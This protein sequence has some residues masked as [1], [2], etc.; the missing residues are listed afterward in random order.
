MKG[1]INIGNTCYLNAG[2]QMLIQ[3]VALCNLIKEYSNSSQILQVLDNFINDYYST[4]KNPIAPINIKK[5]IEQKQEIFTGAGQ[6]DSTEFIIYLLDIIDT[7]INRVS[8]NKI[9]EINSIFGIKFNVSIKCKI[10]ECLQISSH[11]EY[12]SILLLNINSECTSLDDAYRLYKSSEK[13]ELDNRYFCSNCNKK[14]IASK[15]YTIIEWP[16][17]LFIW[18]KRYEQNNNNISKN[19]QPIKINKIWRHQNVLQGAIIHSGSLNGGH[20]VYVG[21][22]SNNKW[23]MFNDSTIYEIKSE[24]ELDSLLSDAYWLYYKKI[25]D[26][27]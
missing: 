10:K 8:T 4:D 1:L 14:R 9:N 24:L 5:I 7:E 3:N 11:D 22:Q 12:T 19:T 23:Y 21:K 6:Q 15:R 26:I 25:I 20:Y 17:Y 16:Q 2:L 27:K 13:L 18:L